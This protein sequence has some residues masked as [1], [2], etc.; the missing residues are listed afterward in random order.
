MVTALDLFFMLF[1]FH[2]RITGQAIRGQVGAEVF[3]V[4][5]ENVFVMQTS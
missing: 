4:T 5:E 1:L 2:V 3:L